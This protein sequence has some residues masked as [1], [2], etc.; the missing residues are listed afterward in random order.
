MEIYN[1]PVIFTR[2]KVNGVDVFVTDELKEFIDYKKLFDM[3]ITKYNEIRRQTNSGRF[4]C[5]LLIFA[6]LCFL[7]GFFGFVMGSI[8]GIIFKVTWL[9]ISSSVVLGLAFIISFGIIINS[10]LKFKRE[11][12]NYIQDKNVNLW[13]KLG[14]YV[15]PTRAHDLLG[16]FV[17]DG[18]HHPQGSYETDPNTA[19]Y[20]K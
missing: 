2:K 16:F 12:R 5:F 7:Y 14:F 19:K 8:N 13:A 4:A 1:F 6:L 15:D 11:F 17:F 10:R 3:L 9:L 20:F 18:N